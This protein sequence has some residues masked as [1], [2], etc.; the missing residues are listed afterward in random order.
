MKNWTTVCIKSMISNM[1]LTYYL[2]D[3]CMTYIT[4][5]KERM[6]KKTD[7]EFTKILTFL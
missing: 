4:H 2:N 1:I 3:V 5:T 6:D 7:S